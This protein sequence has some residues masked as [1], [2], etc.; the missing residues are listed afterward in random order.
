MPT[1]AMSGN[2]TVIINNRVLADF[3]NAKIAE[4]TYP[5]EIANVQTGKNGNSIYSLNESGQK[6]ELKLR[7]VRGSSDDK[8]L[9]ALL[10]LQ[11]LN[12]ES[13]PLM[14][15]E[16]VKRVGDG[17]GNVTSD[18]Y[19]L[20]GGVFTKKPEAQSDVQGDSEQSVS[21][22]TMHFANA[23]RAIT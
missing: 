22:Y 8:F 15:G 23:D 13:F 17:Q 3:A 2:D 1:V 18:T 7:I 11:D 6:G 14:I 4:L 10:N 5:D 9:N 16:L 12:F 21:I 19:I 20:S